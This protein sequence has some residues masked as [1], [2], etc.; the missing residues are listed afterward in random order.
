MSYIRRVPLSAPERLGYWEVDTRSSLTLQ[1]T[2][3]GFHSQSRTEAAF[4]ARAS[5]PRGPYP[6]S[7]T[8]RLPGVRR[9]ARKLGEDVSEVLD[10]I[11]ASFVVVRHVRPKMSC[12]TCSHVVQTP[13][14]AGLSIAPYSAPDF[15]PTWRRLISATIC[16]SIGSR[17]SMP[18][19]VS[20]WIAPRWHAGSPRP[21]ICWSRS[22]RR[23]ACWLRARA[24]PRPEGS[25]PMCATALR[26]AAA[27]LQQCGLPTRRTVK[28]NIRSGTWPLPRHPAG[29]RLCRVQPALRR[30]LDSASPLHGSYPAQVL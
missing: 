2:P 12:G 30:R 3:S 9:H 11:P 29:R 19:R 7:R 17:R 27:R 22:S 6:L 18:A 21:A 23:C 28:A 20:I 1:A 26:R 14:R 10:Y 5:A 24:E 15:W 4:F 25:G 13:R 16:R 8:Q